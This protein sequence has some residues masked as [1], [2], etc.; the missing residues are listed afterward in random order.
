MRPLVARCQL[1]FGQ[2]Y[3]KTGDHAGASAHLTTG[4]MMLREIGMTHWLELADAELP[5]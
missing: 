5:T 3:G 4:I 2:S 1:A